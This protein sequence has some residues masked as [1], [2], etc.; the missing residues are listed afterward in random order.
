MVL[1]FRQELGQ[2]KPVKRIL[3][4]CDLAYQ[5]QPSRMLDLC[6]QKLVFD[7]PQVC[8]TR[9]CIICA[10]FRVCACL[11]IGVRVCCLVLCR[12]E[13]S[14]RNRT[15]ACV[16]CVFARAELCVSNLFL[17]SVL[18]AGS[19]PACTVAQYRKIGQR[20]TLE[21]T[22]QTPLYDEASNEGS[23]L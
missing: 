3:E 20:R 7:T 16:W 21:K 6:R 12:Q 14:D 13:L 10:S 17:I 1:F 4:K 19:I 9:A 5:G 11:R 23:G 18:T 8:C 22:L 2:V 15:Y